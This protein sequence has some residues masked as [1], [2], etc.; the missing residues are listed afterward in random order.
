MLDPF[1]HSSREAVMQWSN[2]DP[3]ARRL[4]MRPGSDVPGVRRRCGTRGA[5]RE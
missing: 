5:C 1:T 2:G 3:G 4:P